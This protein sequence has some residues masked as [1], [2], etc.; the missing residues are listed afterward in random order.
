MKTEENENGNTNFKFTVGNVPDAVEEENGDIQAEPLNIG[1]VSWQKPDLVI[2]M[3]G[4]LSDK[5]IA[6]IGASSGYFAFRLAF[7]A[8][9]VIAVDI[10]PT[11]VQLMDMFK[12][13]LPKKV[14]ERFETRLVNPENPM[15]AENEV[16]AVLIVNTI[17]YIDNKE[18]YLKSLRKSITDGGQIM[19]VDY[20]MKSMPIEAPPVEE[21]IALHELENILQNAG[22]SISK[23]DDTSLEYQFILIAKNSK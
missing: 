7:K 8:A 10:D 4:D 18:E 23:S 19:I 2:G 15:L 16:D 12:L 11:S 22:Y 3:L 20:K 13:N 21:R 17:A 9:K 14:E 1:R 6:D 5:R